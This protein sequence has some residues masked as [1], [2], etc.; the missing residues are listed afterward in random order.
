[1]AK[2][3]HTKNGNVKVVLDLE[4]AEALRSFT[5]YAPALIDSHGAISQRT[6]DIVDC[7]D[8]A[9][10]EAGVDPAF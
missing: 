9:L 5:L 2:V 8:F 7:I 6:L 3:K 10:G 4:E 1:M